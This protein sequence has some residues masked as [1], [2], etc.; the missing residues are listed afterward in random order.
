LVA[1]ARIAVHER[2]EQCIA[3]CKFGAYLGAHGGPG[4]QPQLT[5][6]G[7]FCAL[8]DCSMND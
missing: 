2:T 3:T 1:T 5:S 4:A 8:P 6:L 7:L